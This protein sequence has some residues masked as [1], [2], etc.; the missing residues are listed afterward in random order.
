MAKYI[1]DKG[2][3]G[4]VYTFIDERHRNRLLRD[5]ELVKEIHLMLQQHHER[6]VAKTENKHLELFLISFRFLV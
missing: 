3:H 6:P 1:S 4:A 2:I 5:D